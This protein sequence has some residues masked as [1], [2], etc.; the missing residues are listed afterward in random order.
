MVFGDVDIDSEA[1]P[2]EVL[3]I[4]DRSADARVARRRPDLAGR[5]RRARAGDPDHAR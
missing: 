5:A 1:G 4:A 2:T 3:A